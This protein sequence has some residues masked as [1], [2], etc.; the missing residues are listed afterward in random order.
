MNFLTLF[1]STTISPFVQISL[2]LLWSVKQTVNLTVS[3]CLPSTCYKS[4]YS[5]TLT[6]HVRNWKPFSSKL[7]QNTIQ[8]STYCGVLHNLEQ[9]YLS[10]LVV[11]CLFFSL[12]K[13]MIISTF[14]QFREWIMYFCMYFS[15]LLQIFLIYTME[16]IIVSFLLSCGYK[17][18]NACKAFGMLQTY[19]IFCNLL[20]S[21]YMFWLTFKVNAFRS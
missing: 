1:L 3:L 10:S 20:F 8:V 16:I 4:S 6:D 19:T 17:W 9:T 21:L 15:M 7:L 2:F 18:A 11:Y 14:R 5:K 12:K 13:F